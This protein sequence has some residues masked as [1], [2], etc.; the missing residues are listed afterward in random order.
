MRACTIVYL[1]LMVLTLVTWLVANTGLAGL[2][3]SLSVLALSLFKGQ[4]IGDYFMGLKTVSSGWRWVIAV[5][6]LIPGGLIA[7]AYT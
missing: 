7:Y 3:I 6:L 1:V 2:S 5:W 4:L